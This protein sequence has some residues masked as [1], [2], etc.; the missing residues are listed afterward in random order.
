VNQLRDRRVQ[1]LVLAHLLT[2]LAEWA[3][4]VGLLVHAFAWGGPGAVGVVSIAVLIPPFL[5]APL[6]ALAMA[7]RRAHTI[8]V[9]GFAIQAVTYASAAVLAALDASTPVLAPLV[10]VGLAAST[11][12]HP[13]SAALLARTAP[14]TADLVTGSLWLGYCDSASA[15]VGSLLAAALVG[16][17]GSTAVFGACAVAGATSLLLTMWRPAPLARKGIDQRYASPSRIVRDAFAELRSRPWSRGVLLV[18]SARNIVVG[19]FD[20]LL[21]I[22][23]IDQ[24]DLGDAGPGYLGACVGAGALASTLVTTVAVRRNLRSFMLAALG[25]AAMGCTAIGVW[26]E[27]AV[28]FVVLAATGICIAS[29][30][31]LSRTLLQRSSDPRS[32]GPL[33]A[34]L[35]FVAA[36][37]QLGG[38]LFAQ[39]AYAI[40][41]LRGSLVGLGVL[42]AALGLA[43]SRSL[44][45]ADANAEVPVVE[46][47]LLAGVPAFAAIPTASLERVARTAEAVHV[48]ARRNVLVESERTDACYVVMA[49]TFDATVRGRHQRSLA[50]GDVV[51]EA[52]LLANVAAMS[53]VTAVDDDAVMLRL[54]REPFLVALTGHDVDSTDTADFA[55]ARARY[56]G[57]VEL[58]ERDPRAESATGAETWL[59][60]GAA[61]RAVGAPSFTDALARSARSAEAS[62]NPVLLAEAAALT[63]WPGA[64]FRIADRPDHD[65]IALCRS[66]LTALD[67]DDPLRVRVLATLASHL[68]F[69]SEPTE[70]IAIIAEATELAEQLHDPALLGAALNAEFI[71]LWEP[72]T[73]ERREEIA[74]RLADIA[75]ELGDVELAFVAGFF[76]TYCLAERGH[77]GLARDRLVA[78]RPIIHATHT[79]YFEFLAER[80]VLSIDIARCEANTRE[81]IDVLARRHADTHADTDG[82]WAL[83]LGGLAYQE[84]TL[85]SL[86]DVMASMMDGPLARTWRAA[87]ALAHLMNDDRAAAASLLA[88]QGDVSRNYFWATVTQVQAEVAAGLGDTQ[89]CRD[90]YEQLLPHRGLVG[91]TASGSLCFGLMS[92][93]LG[94]LALALGRHDEAFELLH[95]AAGQADEMPMP[96]ESVVCRRLL[97]VAYAASGDRLTADSMVAAALERAVAHGFAREERHLVQL[98][99]DLAD[100]HHA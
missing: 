5:C 49:G 8:R 68:T 1:R 44:R 23:A 27:H 77:F 46:M 69:A 22:V 83:Q 72:A 33:F 30:D 2:A 11:V 97:A 81:R 75:A 61:G 57:T 47:T 41:G 65:M 82:T 36:L 78:L 63:T 38:S 12:L 88:E 86:L 4:T 10:V 51:G 24:L 39:S 32:L 3:A 67:A 71:C 50:R 14:S 13:T 76:A 9:V 91:I 92:R 21:V 87:L 99:S 85:G 40:V 60:L 52:A 48:P 64:F 79:E 66:A 93:S 35:G 80:L 37:G 31:V 56:R 54:A 84:G 26:P 7:R 98:R 17:G 89:R 19:A 6:V 16:A 45:R 15:L 55:D 95:E 18:A 90:L 94:E 100:T 43:S 34:S 42:L 59:G 20:V 58:L 74:A 96:F 73:I 62:T 70:R 53:T 25:V 28:V 29:M